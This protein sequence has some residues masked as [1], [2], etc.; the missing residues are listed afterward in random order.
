MKDSEKQAWAQLVA[1]RQEQERKREEEMK[2][3]ILSVSERLANERSTFM[4]EFDEE[5][6]RI[7]GLN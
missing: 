5:Q 1:A 3:W 6:K 4:S 7:F 2:A